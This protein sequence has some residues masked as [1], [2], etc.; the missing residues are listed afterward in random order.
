MTDGTN[1]LVVYTDIEAPAD[2]LLTV[3]YSREHLDAALTFTADP[4][5]EREGK[6]QSNSF[7]SEPGTTW[8]YTGEDGGRAK[9]VDGTFDGVPGHFACGAVTC[10][11]MTDA[12]GKLM[13]AEED[14]AWRFTPMAPLTAT[15][16][17]P[18]AAYAYFGWWLDKPEDNK[19]DHMVEV[20][21][22]GTEGHAAD[23]DKLIEGN[24]TYKGPAAGKYTTKTF[25]AG[26]QTDAGVGH[27]TASTTLTAKFLDEI[28]DGTIGGTVTGFVLDDGTSPA[29]S[30]KLEDAELTANQPLFTG[31][32]VATFGPTAKVGGT[33]QGSFYN[34]ADAEDDT[35]PGTV[36][37]TFDAVSD[38]ATLI[39][40]FGATKQ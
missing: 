17:D 34:D 40:G 2:K 27:F 31:V 26:V 33:W 35:A 10:T 37:G 36:A 39:G 28:Q 25:T 4:G 6:A 20:F 5:D 18:D 21:A 19:V 11:L 1:T 29:W 12:D 23:V 13:T 32:S 24:V 8:V 22:G 3:Q 38:N 7:P 16:K 15:V 9:T 14:E 30:V